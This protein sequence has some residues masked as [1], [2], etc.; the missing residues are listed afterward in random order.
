M[1]VPDVTVPD[2]TVPD[3]TV[4]DVT[5]PDVTVPEVRV[6]D[7]L[8]AEAVSS[9]TSVPM[10][11]EFRVAVTSASGPAEQAATV[12]KTAIASSIDV[13]ACRRCR[14]LDRPCVAETRRIG[15]G[16]GVDGERT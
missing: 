5:V 2:V 13:A 12:A 14:P 16:C 1:E 7:S 3:V 8:P 6:P 9:V 11:G 15:C 10:T 4:P